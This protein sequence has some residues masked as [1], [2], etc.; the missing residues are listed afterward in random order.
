[1]GIKLEAGKRYRDGCGN[2]ETITDQ[3]RDGL[4]LSNV[5]HRYSED[6]TCRTPFLAKDPDF[7]LITPAPDEAPE[8]RDSDGA[9]FI[10]RG[11]GELVAFGPPV[12]Q[13]DEL[14]ALRAENALLREALERALGCLRAAAMSHHDSRSGATWAQ[15]V[16]E[17]ETA[18]TAK[19]PAR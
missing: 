3:T 6:G 4:F 9:V 14:A 16:V 5:G 13:P 2:K 1:M 18:L 8:P 15:T 11:S 7:N 17:L 10:Y 12:N 19:E